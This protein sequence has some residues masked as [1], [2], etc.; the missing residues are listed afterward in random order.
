MS[1]LKNQNEVLYPTGK[2]TFLTIIKNE[3]PP[4][5]ILWRVPYEDFNEGSKVIVGEQEIA[6][7]YKNGIVEEAFSGGEYSL[8]TNNYPFLSRIRNSLSGGV[9]AYNCRIIYVNK[10]H[11]LDNKW[12]T[13]GPIQVVD[14]IYDL[15]VDI[16]ARGSYTIQIEDAKKFYLKFAGTTAD[17]LE[18]KDIADNMHG[19]INQ[20]IK[21]TIGKI[22][23]E[24][25]TEIIGINA[26]LEEISEMM[27]T[28]MEGVFKEYGVRMVNFYI[29]A[30][31]IVEDESFMTLK[32]AR[33][34]AVAMV[35]GAHGLKKEATILGSDFGRIKT[36]QIMDKAAGNPSNG[37]VGDGLGLGAGMAMGGV[38][39]SSATSVL[40]PLNAQSESFVPAKNEEK[41]HSRYGF[42]E[43]DIIAPCGHTVHFGMKFCPLCGKTVVN[44]CPDCGAVMTIG[45]K[46]CSQCGRRLE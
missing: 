11:Q 32:Q 24:L 23:S 5:I 8:S 25:Q 42:D 19:P 34:N 44:E 37:L 10:T 18:A 1:L 45:S 15:P 30:L 31:E 46:F 29:E 3:A 20:K 6:L 16:V 2:K 14:K 12:G 26:C 40:T 21:S 33:A 43:S 38:M 17:A 36:A 7:F 28:P 9:S 41:N 4:N 35:I 13:D 27:H 39:A 22:V